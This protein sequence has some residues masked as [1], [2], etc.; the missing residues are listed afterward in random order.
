M[1]QIYLCEDNQTQLETY[2]KIIRDFLVFDETGFVFALATSDPYVLLEKRK[3]NKNPGLYF[4]DIDL[5]ARINGLELAQQIRRL[6]PRGY[7]VFI[8]THSEMLSLTFEYKVEAMD[9]ILKDRPE[10]L[11]DRIR[12]CIHTAKENDTRF[13]KQKENI[14]AI[15]IDNVLVRLNQNDIIFVELDSSPHRLIIHT[16]HG[17]KRIPGT[18][19]ELETN[20]DSR[21]CRCHNSVLV[22]IEHVISFN[23]ASRQLLMDNNEICPVSMRMLS[24]IREI[25][26]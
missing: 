2:S 10:Q 26:F 11:S 6:D 19:K 12:H 23:R 24:K 16:S 20:L 1:I 9:F 4:L 25:L 15:K 18:L 7:I 14:I 5:Q 3:E 22:N 13:Q 8:T 17:V 21:F